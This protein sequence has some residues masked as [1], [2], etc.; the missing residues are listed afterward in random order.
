MRAPS[1]SS[2]SAE[3][4]RLVAERLP[5]LATAQ[6][7]PAAISAAV[8]ETLKRAAPA[9]RAGRVEQVRRARSAR[10]RRARASCA[11]ARP[12]PRPSRPWSAARSGSPRSAISETSPCMISA[13]TSAV[14]SALRSW[15]RGERVDR[16]GRVTL[17]A[18][19]AS[20]SALE[21]VREQLPA[22]L[23]ED[24][25]GVELDALGRQ[26][27]VAQPHQHAAAARGLLQ[28]VGQLRVDHQR[29]VAPD[30]QRRGQ[31]AEDRAPV[32]LDRSSPCRAPARAASRARRTPARAPGGR[33]TR[34]ASGSPPRASAARPR[35]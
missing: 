14:C 20:A 19:A 33:G 17:A 9:A 18:V 28:A 22:L 24:R 32:V 21:E 26:L 27:A 1:A 3:P 6:P 10:A 35:A 34:R 30:R 5:C 25:L 13:S 23:G 8:V 4:E 2:R 31:A 11:P 12:A 16:R 7:A 15:P 29:V